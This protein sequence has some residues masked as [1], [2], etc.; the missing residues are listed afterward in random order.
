MSMLRLP[1]SRIARLLLF[2]ACAATTPAFA[3]EAKV[4]LRGGYYFDTEKPFVG[5]ELLVRVAPRFYF[6][7]NAEYVFVDDAHY[8]TWYGDFHYDFHVG[9]GSF[10]WLGAGLAVTTFDRSGPND[11]T[12]DVGA[13]FLAGV[14]VRTGGVIPYFQAK[15]IAKDSSEFVLGF[16]V[17]F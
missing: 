7:P 14:G 5:L 15:V 4:G 17:R 12:T 10:A 9:H 13:N 1:S 2:F 3:D 11:S 6:N 16:G 8:F